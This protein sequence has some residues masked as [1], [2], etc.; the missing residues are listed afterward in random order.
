MIFSEGLSEIAEKYLANGAKVFIES[1]LRNRK[2]QDQSGADRYSTEIYLT[3]YNG[4]LTVLDARKDDAR[5]SEQHAK[6]EQASGN[7]GMTPKFDD[8]I[9]FGPCGQ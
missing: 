8:E 1:A 6:R 5:S 9:P 7:D 3:Q 2:W 4:T